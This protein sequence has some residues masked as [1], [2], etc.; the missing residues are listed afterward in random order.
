MP[1]KLHRKECEAKVKNIKPA[2]IHTSFLTINLELTLLTHVNALK[3]PNIQG[4]IEQ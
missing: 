2:V 4:S 1:S 3:V